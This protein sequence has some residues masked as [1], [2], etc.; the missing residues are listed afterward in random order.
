[1][2][3]EQGTWEE[4][5]IQ[6]VIAPRLGRVR[7]G[8]VE[9]VQ[10]AGPGDELPPVMIDPGALAFFAIEPDL[11]VPAVPCDVARPAGHQVSVGTQLKTREGCTDRD[12]DAAREGGRLLC[13][14]LAG[15]P[16]HPLVDHLAPIREAIG[17][18]NIVR[19]QQQAMHRGL[20]PGDAIG[21]RAV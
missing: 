20:D 21:G 14:A 13:V 16:Y 1:M 15:D 10:I 7:H 5:D 18:G 12:G 11:V 4:P 8:R 2:R 17:L 3:I 6:V 9:D 19:R